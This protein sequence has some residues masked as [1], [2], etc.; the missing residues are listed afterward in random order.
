MS[1]REWRYSKCDRETA[2]MIAEECKC[3][4]FLALLLCCKGITNLDEVDEFLSDEINL[5]DADSIDGISDAVDLI[6]SEIENGGKIGIFG[7]Y[8]ADGVTSTA[9]LVD[10]LKGLH[11][12]VGWSVPLRENGYGIRPEDVDIFHQNGVTLIITVDNGITAFTA[13]ERAKELG[14]KFIITDH[15]LPK[16]TL[17]EANVTINPHILG[18]SAEFQDY[19]GVGVAFMLASALLQIHPVECLD[20]YGDWVA[21]GTVADVV[22]LKSDNRSI[23]R[24][25]VYAMQNEITLP[26]ECLCDVAGVDRSKMDARSIA[27]ALSPRIN[28]AGRMGDAADAVNLLLCNDREECEKL[29][30]KLNDYNVERKKIEGEIF[31]EAQHIIESDT[32]RLY[33]PVLMVK[34]ENWHSGVLGIVASKLCS[35]YGKPTIVMSDDGEL[36]SGSA[37]SYSGISLFDTL[38]VATD[39]LNSFG[40]H[41]L[42]AGLTIKSDNYQNACNAIQKSAMSL[43]ESIP[44]PSID[45]SLKLNPSALSTDAVKL[46][47]I[48]E[49]YGCENEEP[50]YLLENLMITQITPVGKAKNHIKLTLTRDGA[51]VNAMCFFTKPEDFH[52]AVYDTVDLAVTLGINEYNGTES[53]TVA[54][55]DIHISYMSYYNLGSDMRLYERYKTLGEKPD[56]IKVNRND[57]QIMWRNVQKRRVVKG[58][59]DIIEKRIGLD[60]WMKTRV[61]LDILAELGFVKIKFDK[62]FTVEF[63]DEQAKNPLENSPTYQLFK[64][65]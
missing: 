51:T 34:G 6:K 48:L 8:D 20:Y 21:L 39:E 57:V 9:L 33:Q 47:Q 60:R 7:D 62:Y 64:A 61:L 27:F 17:P 50:L 15:H 4:K 42:A 36:V 12:D 22:P 16:D 5:S 23:V 35:L 13:C 40:G 28:A 19:A 63:V 56:F 37:R 2:S 25:G 29:A 14:I 55:R 52:F 41:E 44:L 54:V 38:T 45:I 18:S 11:A 65:E 46:T 31:E 24:W 30:K 1:V 10:C 43:Y 59:E 3:S 58:T 32:D 26:I 49:P 53:L